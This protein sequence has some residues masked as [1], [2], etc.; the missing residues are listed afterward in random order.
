MAYKCGRCSRPY[1][2]HIE[3]WGEGY[4]AASMPLEWHPYKGEIPQ[5]ETFEAQ[6]TVLFREQQAT[7][8]QQEAELTRWKQHFET[9]AGYVDAVG[10]ALDQFLGITDADEQTP[11]SLLA[12]LIKERLA[13]LTRLRAMESRVK[14]K[15]EDAKKWLA[16]AEADGSADTRNVFRRD[17]STLAALL[18][19]PTEQGAAKVTHGV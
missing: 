15:L 10:E 9:E 6:Y 16:I 18:A 3:R 17:I 7:L 14:D 5:D 12:G 1:A 2:Y 11:H 8:Q 13:E 19:P 4:H